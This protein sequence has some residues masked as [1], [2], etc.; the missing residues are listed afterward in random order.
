MTN[1]KPKGRLTAK[2]YIDGIL[3]GDRVILSRGITIVESN[4]ESDKK[5]AKEIIQAILPHS[6]NSIRIGITGVPGVGKSTFIEAFGKYLIGQGHKVGILSIDPSSQRSKGSILG[7]KTRMEEL[8]NMEDAYIRPSATGDTLG[9][10]ANKTGESMLLCEAA[11]YDI[12]LIE[13]V[14][15]GQSETAVHGMTDFF[16]LLMLSGAGDELQGIKKG[17]MEMADMV[18]I[19]KADGDNIKKS[20]MARRQYQNALHIF[21]LSESGWSPVVTTASAIK[22]IG[23]DTVWEEISK[24]KKQVDENGY[25]IK[26]RNHQQI[27]WMYNNINEELKQLFYGSKNI[28]DHLSDLEKDIISSKI[29]P[30]EAAQNIIQEFKNSI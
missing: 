23:I 1:Y 6:G 21:P 17:I 4:L 18:V 25:F 8:A 3:K 29:S 7:D 11:G 19:N 30:V 16:L 24:Y 27:K 12:I 22:N 20:E 28:A 26:N 15:V 5:L 10:V 2:E 13:T 14:G 9:G